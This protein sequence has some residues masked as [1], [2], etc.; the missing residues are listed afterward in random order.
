MIRRMERAYQTCDK[1]AVLSSAS[2]HSFEEF[3]YG[4]KTVVVL[5][6]I[7]HTFFTPAAERK[8]TSLFRVC[9]VGRVELAK[10][11]AYLLEAWKGLALLNAEL[12]LI[13]EVK[14]DIRSIL[15]DDSGDGLKLTGFLPPLQVAEHYRRSDVFVFPSINEGFGLVLLEAMASGLPVVAVKDTGADDC[16]IDGKE[17][18]IVPA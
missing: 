10:G 18:V 12:T 16:V 15:K 7:D 8:S 4:Q 9:Y 14:P 13:G 11:L 5:P 2:R 3:G 1:L 17:G 6:G